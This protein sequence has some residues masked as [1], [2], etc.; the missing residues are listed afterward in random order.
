MHVTV[1]LVTLDAP[2]ARQLEPRAASPQARLQLVRALREAKVPVQVM[3]APLIPGITDAGMPKLLEAAADSGAQG[4]GYE[5]LRLPYQLKALYEDWLRR[6]FPQ[7]APYALALLRQ[8]HGGK[9]YDA[10]IGRRMRGSGTYAEH[11]R[12]TFGVFQRKTHLD[13]ALP[14]LSAAAFQPPPP[15]AGLQLRLW[16]QAPRQPRKAGR[17]SDGVPKPPSD[18]CTAGTLFAADCR[19][20]CC[21]RVP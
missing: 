9:L 5:I 15:R 17:R 20:G 3:V 19:N 13:G 8:V 1:T 2:L 16:S 10:T 4:A 18:A 11:L 12:K 6:R 7:R 14:G 21:R